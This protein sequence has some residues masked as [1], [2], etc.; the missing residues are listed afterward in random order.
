MQEFSFKSNKSVILIAQSV[1]RRYIS[2][3][4]Y[5]KQNFVAAIGIKLV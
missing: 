1:N 5:D 2:L 4:N 3:K